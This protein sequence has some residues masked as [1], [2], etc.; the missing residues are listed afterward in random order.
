MMGM[1]P[2]SDAEALMDDA[3]FLK[4]LIAFDSSSF[5]IGDVRCV[6]RIRAVHHEV[7]KILVEASECR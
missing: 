3:G 4:S 1:R 5:D 7:V 2:A 6:E